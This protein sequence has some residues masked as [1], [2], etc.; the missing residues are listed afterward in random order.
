MKINFSPKIIILLIIIVTLSLLIFLDYR[1]VFEKPK[2]FVYKIILPIQK[3]LYQAGNKASNYS[4]LLYSLP[5][6]HNQNQWLRDQNIKLQVDI[7][8]LNEIKRENEI[9][10]T[11]LNLKPDEKHV[12]VLA[13]VVGYGPD[14]FSQYI[15][16]DKGKRDGVQV[17]APVTKGGGVLVG[18]IIETFETTS[19]A[20]LLTD[21][22]SAISVVA[23]KTRTAGILKSDRGINLYLDMIP[24][25][26]NIEVGEDII[27]SGIGGIFPKG[28]LVGEVRE[29]V[30]NDAD[31]FKKVKI[32][33]A[34][35][36]SNLEM[37]FV[38]T[39]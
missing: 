1:G 11:Q 35:D 4:S 3:F 33:P 38:I 10:R 12:L 30:A 20:L 9:L 32:N 7:S 14:N 13:N 29:I 18:R 26:A 19:K 16:I 34:A 21:H 15:L 25:D 36:F 6:L 22:S 39:Q 23:Q 8:R 17:N 5:T 31:A 2:E 28:F 27:T 24:Q 37:I